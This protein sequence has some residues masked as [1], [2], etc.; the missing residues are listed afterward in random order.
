MK[1]YKIIFLQLAQI[2]TDKK[3]K[4]IS[5]LICAIC[6][7]TNAQTQINLQ[8][9]IETALK[10]NL[11]VKNEK[12]N[13]EYQ[14]KLKASAVD[15]P[16][17]NLTGEYGQIN[18][19]YNDTKFG[20][21]QSISFPTVYT[22]QKS[23]QNETYKSSVLNIAVK[24]AE[25][26]KQVSEVFYLLV[27]LN[28]KQNILLKNDSVYASFLE[29]ANL[30]FAKGETNIL[31]KTTAETQRGQIAIQLNQL[32]NDIE[33]LQLQFQFLLNTTTVFT[34]LSESPKMIFTAMLDTSVI[35]KHPTLLV[36]QQQKEIS[37][38]K[39][40]LE[41]S[42][43]LPNLNM[44]Y[45]NMSM[46]GTGADNIFYNTSTRFN[47]IQFG[48]DVPLFFG[49]QKAK[50]NSSKTLQLISENNFQIGLRTLNAEYQKAFKQYQTQ[51]QTVKYFEETAL[52]NA[53][54]ITKTANQQ[55]A[56]GG[57][58]YLEWTIL[59][60]NAVNIQSNYTDAVKELNQSIIQLN[61]LTSK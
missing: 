15:I 33:I 8:V 16:Q 13:A 4:I 3:V 32:K 43:L 21:S 35:S 30:R 1:K 54:T 18:S 39:I 50:I 29:K 5:T 34:P 55:F 42:K 7:T 2:Y 56:N 17:T 59:I 41:K 28:Q 57:I 40:Q 49:L 47:S 19:F 58:N 23:L 6:G 36:L 44:G 10:N 46:K 20:I 37:S 22:K 52:K 11:Q 26:K 61:F 48:L 9:A 45:Y 25:L 12:L 53:N 27:Y 60:N 14:Q 31:E 51:L 38:V 24:E